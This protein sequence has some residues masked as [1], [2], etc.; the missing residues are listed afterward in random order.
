MRAA[1]VAGILLHRLAWIV[2]SRPRD[3]MLNHAMLVRNRM[4]RNPVTATPEEPLSSAREKML[5]GRFRRLPVLDGGHL[6]GILTDRDLL[7]A[8]AKPQATAVG[9]AMTRTPITVS[10]R[11]T[12]ELAARLMLQ[13][14]ISGLP[15]IEETRLVGVITTT[16]VMDAFLEVTGA[17]A[18]GTLRVDFAPGG[19]AT[20]Q[21]AEAMARRLGGEVLSTGAYHDEERNVRYLRVR[22]VQPG[23]IAQALEREGFSVLGVHP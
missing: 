13:H 8:G 21:D 3:G 11:A 10:P 5:R 20:S 1:A 4:T 7:R 18:D 16:D 12:V 22:G 19:A 17:S 6:V 14:R 9:D 15:V 2:H 23:D